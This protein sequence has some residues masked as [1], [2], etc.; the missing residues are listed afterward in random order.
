[1]KSQ[2]LN[3]WPSREFPV[4]PL[5][6]QILPWCISVKRLVQGFTTNMLDHSLSIKGLLSTYWPKVIRESAKRF[7]LLT[8]FL[9]KSRPQTQQYKSYSTFQKR[10]MDN[11]P[12]LVYSGG[13][14][15]Q[16]THLANWVLSDL[17]HGYNSF[18]WELAMD[19]QGKQWLCTRV[20]SRKKVNTYNYKV[21]MSI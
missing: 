11:I 15:L 1:M 9:N 20:L 3:H 18:N 2:S 5:S 4:W 6:T 16:L 7:R 10:Q 21:T 19:W 13:K 14:G 17:P 12:C 8:L